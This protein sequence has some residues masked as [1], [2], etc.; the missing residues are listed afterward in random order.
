MKYAL[1]S[2]RLAK[3][4]LCVEID[5]GVND[6]A[7][8]IAK[9]VDLWPVELVKTENYLAIPSLGPLTI[10]HCLIVTR[11]HENSVVLNAY[12]E[13]RNEELRQIMDEM[14]LLLKQITGKARFLYFEHGSTA[15][16]VELC[17]TS[18]AHL[19]VIPLGN[20]EYLKL[21]Y[22][23][24]KFLNLVPEEKAI[25]LSMEC[26]DFILAN[27][28]DLLDCLSED[29][30]YFKESR[31]LKSQ[32][33]RRIVAEVLKVEVWNWK[34]DVRPDVVRKLVDEFRRA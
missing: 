22:R 1:S 15:S 21:I 27:T 16:A 12:R 11:S 14:E 13:K 9:K 19:H 6:R 30:W 10:G 5:G 26:D 2:N 8:E 34:I 17:S 25:R 24:D 32:F 3:C 28:R 23:V 7:V 29:R 31:G 33:M 20:D 18:H 4:A